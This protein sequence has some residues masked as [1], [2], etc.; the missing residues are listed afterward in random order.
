MRLISDAYCKSLMKSACRLFNVLKCTYNPVTAVPVTEPLFGYTASFLQQASNLNRGEVG[1]T[2][3]RPLH[4][5]NALELASMWI[6]SF[7]EVREKEGVKDWSSLFFCLRT[8][9]IL[10]LLTNWMNSHSLPNLGHHISR[11]FSVPNSK[12]PKIFNLEA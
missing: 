5:V 11:D 4:T 12:A 6:S 2:S 10:F 3:L 9:H 7:A 8:H 1:Q